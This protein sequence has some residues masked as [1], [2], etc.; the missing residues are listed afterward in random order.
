MGNSDAQW[1]LT[2]SETRN[3]IINQL[4]VGDWRAQHRTCSNAFFP[5]PFYFIFRKP[6]HFSGEFWN[7]SSLQQLHRQ[8]QRPRHRQ[9][10]PISSR[11]PRRTHLFGPHFILGSHVGA[12]GSLAGGSIPFG[13]VSIGFW[14]KSAFP[15]IGIGRTAEAPGSGHLLCFFASFTSSRVGWWNS[16]SYCYWCAGVAFDW[17]SSD[18]S[19]KSRRQSIRGC[20]TIG[21]SMHPMTMMMLHIVILAATFTAAQCFQ[22]NSKCVL[23]SMGKIYVPC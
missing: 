12:N 2:R 4:D 15:N 6:T 23:Q 5:L 9:R 21:D 11:G 16:A 19:A 8:R 18:E 14:A 17:S 20:I 3:V 7:P 22:L 10:S 13:R 1:K